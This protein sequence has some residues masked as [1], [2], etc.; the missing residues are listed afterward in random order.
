MKASER[1]YQEIRGR[2]AENKKYYQEG[3]G[4]A[5][6]PHTICLSVNNN[7]FMRCKMCDIGSANAGRLETLH[8]GYFSNRYIKEKKYIEFPIERI[9]EL[10]DE[11][12]PYKP[13]IKSNFVEPL[14][15]KKLR[16]AAEYIKEKGLKY[17][18]ITNGW[19]LK[20]NASWLVE[21]ETDVIRVS[22]D[23]TEKVHDRIRGTKGSFARTIS[24]IKE[25]LTHKK[26]AGCEVPI[27]G[28]CF[29]ISN[30][31]YFNLV[32]FMRKL[33]HEDILSEVY[34]NFNHLQYTTAWEVEKTKQES[35]LF[36]DLQECSIDNV[37]FSE[38]DI[39]ILKRQ[40]DGLYQ[41]Y[42]Q[43]KYH[44][45]FSPWLNKED[46]AEFYNPECWMFPR[47]KCYLPWYA[48]Q[49]DIGGDVGVYGHCILPS[50]GNIFDRSFMDV[51][52]SERAVHIRREL[53]K[54]NSYPGC[55]RCIGTL[56]P[57]RGRD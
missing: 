42:D 14:L 4:Q 53:K 25:L 43:Q 30:Y 26:N 11:M 21:L 35:E 56:Y 57:L 47:T 2:E 3:D 20:K 18:T 40:I 34:V 9:K 50:F 44:Y 55:N 46:L 19:T 12:A 28:I 27:V 31:N 48:T 23:G 7:C 32:D 49:I 41:Q 45:Y 36:Q 33:E 15:Y 6:P 17:Y 51:W 10:V 8:E 24:G 22:L 5:A 38:I 29:T 16:E 54:V 39:E 37:V 1:E 13:I 52:N